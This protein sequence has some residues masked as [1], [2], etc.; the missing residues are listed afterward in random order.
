MLIL[1]FEAFP[2]KLSIWSS[3]RLETAIW[4]NLAICDDYDDR[5]PLNVAFEERFH[6][7]RYFSAK[8]LVKNTVNGL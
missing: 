1:R 4:P 5:Y 6:I 2:R 8:Q 7:L 3:M